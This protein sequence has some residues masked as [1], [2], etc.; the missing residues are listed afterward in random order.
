[1]KPE[2]CLYCMNRRYLDNALGVLE[3]CPAC[4]VTFIKVS[5][6]DSKGAIQQAIVAV[7]KL[8]AS[9]KEKVAS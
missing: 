1:M 3:R 7:R 6:V 8:R 2:L 5:T 9:Q 4:S